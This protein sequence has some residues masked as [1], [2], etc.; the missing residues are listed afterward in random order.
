[1]AVT[2]TVLWNVILVQDHFKLQQ[3]AQEAASREDVSFR[4]FTYPLGVLFLLSMI[5]GVPMYG[6]KLYREVHFNQRQSD[7]ISGVTHEFK[8]PLAAIRL[9]TETMLARSMSEADRERFLRAILH[10]VDRLTRLINNVLA[11]GKIDLHQSDYLKDE[12]DLFAFL[13]DYHRERSLWMVAHGVGWEVD[14]PGAAFVTMDV[15]ALRIVLDNLVENA[16]KYSDDDRNVTLEGVV[17][18]QEVLL[19]VKDRGIGMVAADTAHAF[20]RFYRGTH[21]P[22]RRVP[23]TGLGLFLVKHIID[24]HGGRVQITSG[25]P[26]RGTTV[27]VTLP[28]RRPALTLVPHVR[29]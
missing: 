7:F 11:A 16:L 23:G 25:G 10:D 12:G 8:S 18:G 19:R 20:E 4:W 22:R 6:V 27:E 28:L 24:G 15:D 21:Q 14:A 29:G 1:M 13:R 5:I 26:G 17:H 2:L 3:L 9:A